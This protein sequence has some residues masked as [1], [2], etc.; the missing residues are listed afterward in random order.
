MFWGDLRKCY[1][2]TP[3]ESGTKV[4]Q[5]HSV[6][7]YEGGGGLSADRKKNTRFRSPPDYYILISCQGLR[8]IEPVGSIASRTYSNVRQ[9]EGARLLKLP[10]L[11]PKHALLRLSVMYNIRGRSPHFADT[12]PFPLYLIARNSQ[13]KSAERAPKR[14]EHFPGKQSENEMLKIPK[15]TRDASIYRD[16]TPFPKTGDQTTPRQR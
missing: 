1:V 3:L 11:P 4:L 16:K 7:C 5:Q 15:R 12:T 13:I 6:L 14:F 10:S 2:L 9:G 8:C